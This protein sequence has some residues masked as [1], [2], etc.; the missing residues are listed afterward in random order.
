MRLRGTRFYN[1]RTADKRMHVGFVVLFIGVNKFIL[2]YQIVRHVRL[3]GQFTGCSSTL[4]TVDV[5]AF[6]VRRC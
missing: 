3:R 6:S 5:L 4:V 2:Y 1:M